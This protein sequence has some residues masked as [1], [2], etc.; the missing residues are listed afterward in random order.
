MYYKITYF[1]MGAFVEAPPHCKTTFFIGE[2]QHYSLGED[3][4]LQ[5][6]LPT[7]LDHEAKPHDLR[8]VSNAARLKNHPRRKAP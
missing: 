4:P 7:A 1:F 5:T 6:S 3:A 2:L 8:L